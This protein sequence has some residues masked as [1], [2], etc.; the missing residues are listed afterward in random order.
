ME[1][2]ELIKNLEAALEAFIATSPDQGALEAAKNAKNLLATDPTVAVAVVG[3]VFD[4]P[5]TAVTDA[6][7]TS[8]S[9]LAARQVSEARKQLASFYAQH[10][11]GQRASELTEKL[12]RIKK[13]GGYFARLFGRQRDG[14]NHWTVVRVGTVGVAGI[15]SALAPADPSI[16]AAVGWEAV[17]VGFLFFP[18]IVCI[19]LCVLL[20]FRGAKLKW[21]SPAWDRNP[22]DF[23][24]PEQFF[25][26]AG[27]GMLAT[28]AGLFVAEL[29]RDGSGLVHAFV[30]AALG[31]G[32]LIGLQFLG[33]VAKRQSKRDD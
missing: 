13:A 31:A 9:N 29:G 12:S 2:K 8:S 32:V 26:M 22:F 6:C 7:S 33:F 11:G 15:S 1:E 17:A 18:G 25:H 23:S 16:E 28:S 10:R 21:E 27:F 30:A 19:G 14:M 5:K 3:E 24:Q 20:P 4:G